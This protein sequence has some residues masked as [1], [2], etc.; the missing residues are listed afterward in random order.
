MNNNRLQDLIDKRVINVA[1]YII[2]TNNTVRG[3]ARVFGVGKTTIHKDL[4]ERLP[5][6][7]KTNPIANNMLNQIGKIMDY[8]FSIKH[9]RGGEATKNKYK[10][11]V[12]G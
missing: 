1:K 2:D 10:S 3:A 11:K 12:G 5:E 8:N 6:M 9:M 7:A 4:S